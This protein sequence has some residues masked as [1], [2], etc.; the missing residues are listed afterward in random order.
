MWMKFFQGFQYLDLSKISK[1]QADKLPFI[2]RNGKIVT[3]LSELS[4]L[5]I[6]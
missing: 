4:I 2:L 6:L 1:L 3:H 5:V